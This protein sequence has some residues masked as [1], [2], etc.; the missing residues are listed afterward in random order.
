MDCLSIE[1]SPYQSIMIHGWMQPCSVLNWR[2]VLNNPKLTWQFLRSLGIA[3]QE[4]KRIQPDPD[5]WVKHCNIRLFMLPDMVC[6][7]VHPIRHLCADISEIW[8]MQLTSQQ[9][10]SMGVTYQELV[11]IG[12][13]REIMARWAFPLSRWHALGLRAEDIEDWPVQDSARAFKLSTQQAVSEL[14]RMKG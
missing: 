12:L 2:H 6:F 10:Q 1:L 14:R 7:P 3:P 8:Q 11:D 5:M 9:L 13:T 4:L